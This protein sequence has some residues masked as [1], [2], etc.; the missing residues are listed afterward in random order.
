M[1]MFMNTF[2]SA[3]SFHAISLGPDICFTSKNFGAIKTGIGASID[4]QMKF[5]SPLGIQLHVGYNHFNNKEVANDIVNLTPVRAGIV[6]FLYQ[7]AIFIFVD[8]GVSHYSASNGTKQ[9]GFSFGFGPGYKLYFSSTTKQ[10]VQFS[11]YYNLHHFYSKY[12][13]G[14]NYTWFNI[15]AAYGISFGKRHIAK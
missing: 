7:D 1:L 11:A 9:N 14:Y 2:L 12:T 5:K 15:R 10:F 4:Y 13:G 8:A 3:Q 6:Y